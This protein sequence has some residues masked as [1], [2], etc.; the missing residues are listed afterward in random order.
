MPHHL[1]S[2]II[3]FSFAI[4]STNANTHLSCSEHWTDSWIIA[5]RLHSLTLSYNFMKNRFHVCLWQR[6]VKI[7]FSTIEWQRRQRGRAN[8]QGVIIYNVRSNGT[9]WKTRLPCKMENRCRHSRANIQNDKKNSE[10]VNKRSFMKMK[11][12]LIFFF[13]FCFWFFIFTKIII[14]IRKYVGQSRQCLRHFQCACVRYSC[15]VVFFCW[16]G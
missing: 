12:K 16:T 5:K 9:N 15:S 11:K 14:I 10:K 13:L 3:K 4:R 7:R 2:T 6:W 1:K 8:D